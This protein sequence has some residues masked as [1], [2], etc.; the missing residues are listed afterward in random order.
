MSDESKKYSVSEIAKLAQVSP[1]T[2]RFYDEKNLVSPAKIEENGYRIYTD[3]ELE[4]LKLISYLKE[5][6]FTLKDIKK[7]LHDKNSSQSF[8]LLIE[9]QQQINEEKI[10]VLKDKQKLLKDFKKILRPRNIKNDNVADITRLMKNEAK[11]TR[12]RR[13]MW[14]YAV[15][16]FLVEISGIYGTVIAGKEAKPMLAV[17]IFTIMVILI[18]IFGTLLT[19]KYYQN[20]AY[21]CPNCGNEFIPK[22]RKF[23]W[24]AHTPKFRK[25]RCPKCNEKSYCLEVAR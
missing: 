9:R 3:K 18:A 16:L 4:Q 23:F 13:K 17:A 14:I 19:L 12:Y 15:I 10:A 25:L 20:V 1:R 11:L 5:L 24:A 22:L 6:G 8:R 21:I 2:V 7:L